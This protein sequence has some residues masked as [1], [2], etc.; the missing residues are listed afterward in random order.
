MDGSSDISSVVLRCVIADDTAFLMQMVV[1]GL[2][3][4]LAEVVSLTFA[5][6]P[7]RIA[8]RACELLLQFGVGFAALVVLNFA[9]NI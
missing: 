4:L 8:A 3:P 7:R 1:T 9:D 6:P 5:K 2:V